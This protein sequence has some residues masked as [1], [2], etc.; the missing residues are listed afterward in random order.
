MDSSAESLG[1]EGIDRSRNGGVESEDCGIDSEDCGNRLESC[2]VDFEEE[3]IDRVGGLRNC[4]VSFESHMNRF[5]S[6]IRDKRRIHSSLHSQA[7]PL[8]FSQIVGF[9]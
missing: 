2:R 6:S 7:C 9:S 5:A 3:N 8:L 1:T 4:N